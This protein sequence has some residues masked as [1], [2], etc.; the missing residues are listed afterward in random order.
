MNIGL[1][2]TISQLFIV[3]FT[4][5]DRQKQF[6]QSQKKKGLVEL[7]GVWLDPDHAEAVRREAKELAKKLE[8]LKNQ[9]IRL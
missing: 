8:T 7:R 2:K 5:K 1:T 6:R 9:Q 4:N 3:M